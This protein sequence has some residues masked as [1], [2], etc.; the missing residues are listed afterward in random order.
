MKISENLP[1]VKKF[2][3]WY[4][5]KTGKWEQLSFDFDFEDGWIG[6]FHF[7]DKDEES[8]LKYLYNSGKPDR[9]FKVKCLY[10]N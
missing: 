6:P 3:V 8:L 9:E 7:Y 4:K 2:H 5:F 1:Q 10:D